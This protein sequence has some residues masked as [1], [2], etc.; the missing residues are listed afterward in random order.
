MKW[1]FVYAN[2]IGHTKVQAF[3]KA[4]SVPAICKQC[5]IFHLRNE[6]NEK[7]SWTHEIKADKICNDFFSEPKTTIV[8]KTLVKKNEEKKNA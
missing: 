6:N 5:K 1:K 2:F 8:K 7:K 4:K 3:S